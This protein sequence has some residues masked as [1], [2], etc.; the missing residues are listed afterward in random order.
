MP[1]YLKPIDLGDGTEY[2]PANGPEAMAVSA[3]YEA[4][5]DWRVRFE[6]LHRCKPMAVDYLEWLETGDKLA[7]RYLAK[8]PLRIRPKAQPAS[9]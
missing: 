2:V 6:S 3:I 9:A 8:N 4:H 5:A 7:P 1:D